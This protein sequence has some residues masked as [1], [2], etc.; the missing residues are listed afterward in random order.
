[1]QYYDLVCTK[2]T[3]FTYVHCRLMTSPATCF[4]PQN[5]QQTINHHTSN[6]DTADTYDTLLPRSCQATLSFVPTSMPITPDL[7]DATLDLA[8]EAELVHYFDQAPDNI[9]GDDNL[10][11]IA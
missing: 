6:I 10:L 9:P 3:N 5:I 2:C 4:A 11:S 7:S 8:E 1:M